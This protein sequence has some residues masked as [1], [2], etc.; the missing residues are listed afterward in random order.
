MI[1]ITALEITAIIF[2][3]LAVIIFIRMSTLKL[4]GR[5]IFSLKLRIFISLLFPLFVVIFILFGFI[6]FII[7]IILFIIILFALIFGRFRRI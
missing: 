6:I 1:K 2:F 4:R 3:L 5:S 7:L